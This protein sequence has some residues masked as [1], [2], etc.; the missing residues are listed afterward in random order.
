VAK[1]PGEFEL[2]AELFAPL[3]AGYP[4]AL[5]LKD[6]AAIVETPPGQCLVVTTDTIVAGVHFLPDDPAESVARKLLRVNLS[7]LAAKAARPTLYLLSLSMPESTEIGWLRDF[8]FGLALDQREFD[9]ALAGGDTTST[10]GP[11]TLTVTAL[12]EIGHGKEIRRSG[13][14]TG[15][16]VFVSGTLGEA[17]LGLKS[18]RGELANL[19]PEH[20]TALVARYRV[21]QPRVSLGQSLVGLATACCDVSD[22]LVA[23]LG[24]IC[25]TSRVAA[26]IAV[27][28][29]P[30]SPAT[31]AALAIDPDLI[32][33]VATGGDDYELVFT[34][35]ASQAGEVVGR[36][37]DLGVAVAEIG[38][39]VPGA[40][41]ALL[42]PQGR[43]LTLSGA[44][45][46]H[47]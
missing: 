14:R 34:A 2:I 11:L 17:A 12:G 9:I 6:D 42:D 39:C 45:W 25:E 26:E 8:A 41:V 38:Q 22:G 10:P 1:R 37:R 4:G 44:G 31:R 5:D 24:H 29:I 32:K 21:P 3:A 18:L 35:P 40:G 19:A 20:R 27:D 7:D 15:D 43:P 16:R 47:F 23:D 46:R 28:R 36:A 13:A 33:L 30:L